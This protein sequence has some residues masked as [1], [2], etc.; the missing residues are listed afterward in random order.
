MSY[1][2]PPEVNGLQGLLTGDSQWIGLVHTV[3][4]SKP[5]KSRQKS[6]GFAN[7]QL[8]LISEVYSSTSN[9]GNFFP[10][11]LEKLI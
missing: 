4:T 9:L 10:R 8:I 5:L 2:I 3:H 6:K 11:E 7:A 1:S